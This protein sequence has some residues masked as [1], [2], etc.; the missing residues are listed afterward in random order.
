MRASLWSMVFFFSLFAQGQNK[1][2]TLSN[3]ERWLTLTPSIKV[4]IDNLSLPVAA[5]PFI[6]R[7]VLNLLPSDIVGAP[8]SEAIEFRGFCQSRTYEVTAVIPFSGK[9]R[10]GFVEPDYGYE[11]IGAPVVMRRVFPNSNMSRVFKVYCR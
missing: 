11:D 1:I 2:I 6:G 4:E 8:Q 10:S 7:V 3:G 5:D 9:D